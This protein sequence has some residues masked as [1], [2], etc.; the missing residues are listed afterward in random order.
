MTTVFDLKIGDV[1]DW[2]GETI[3][4][5]QYWLNMWLTWWPADNINEFFSTGYVKL[6]NKANTQLKYSELLPGDV[7]EYTDG[8]LFGK[9]RTVKEIVDGKTWFTTNTYMT[10]DINEGSNEVWTF[11][12]ISGPSFDK[13]NN[14]VPVVEKYKPASRWVVEAEE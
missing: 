3:K 5:S 10:D 8:H 14:P 9:Q 13:L 11:K 2:G 12:L 6:I 7:I 4:V 1:V